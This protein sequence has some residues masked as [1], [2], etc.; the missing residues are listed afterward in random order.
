LGAH[1]HYL[2]RGLLVTEPLGFRDYSGQKSRCYLCVYKTGSEGFADAD[3]HFA[4]AAGLGVLPVYLTQIVICRAGVHR[5]DGGVMQDP[6]M[7]G[8]CGIQLGAL[9]DSQGD[10]DLDVKIALAEYQVLLTDARPV[11]SNKY[12]NDVVLD[13]IAQLIGLILVER[14]NKISQAVGIGLNRFFGLQKLKR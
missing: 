11:G 4:K 3:Q 12:P 5:N 8:D 7:G 14:D 10:Y 2:G 13:L 6:A 1:S 9:C